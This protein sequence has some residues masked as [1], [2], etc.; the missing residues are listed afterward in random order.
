VV[1]DVPGDSDSP[2]VTSSNLSIYR[3]SLLEVLLEVE[4]MCVH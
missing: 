4:C 1:G 3:L 2:V